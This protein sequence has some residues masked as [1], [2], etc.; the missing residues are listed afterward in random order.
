[1]QPKTPFAF[2][3]PECEVFYPAILFLRPNKKSAAL[4]AAPEKKN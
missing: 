4:S 2:L 1:M 3:V